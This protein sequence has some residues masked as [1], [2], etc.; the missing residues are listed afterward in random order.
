MTSVH[1][2][3]IVLLMLVANA[4]SIAYDNDAGAEF[5]RYWCDPNKQKFNI[6]PESYSDPGTP[7]DCQQMTCHGMQAACEPNKHFLPDRERLRKEWRRIKS[8]PNFKCK[9]AE[10]PL[11][12]DGTLSRKHSLIDYLCKNGLVSPPNNLGMW[13]GSS[14]PLPR[15]E[16]GIRARIP[17]LRQG[18]I[19]EIGYGN[20]QHSMTVVKILDGIIYVGGS[21]PH[22]ND[23]DLCKYITN[24]RHKVSGLRILH[25]PNTL[26]NCREVQCQFNCD[27]TVKNMGIRHKWICCWHEH[28]GGDWPLTS[29]RSA[30]ACLHWSEASGT[31]W[32][33]LIT[34]RLTFAGCSD[35]VMRLESYSTLNTG[36]GNSCA[37]LACTTDAR[38]WFT[39]GNGDDDDTI[40][41]VEMECPR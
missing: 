7:G 32:D 6:Y 4:L 9:N 20:W 23:L 19:L 30:Y 12:A 8:D 38:D 34:P 18:D 36:V 14:G 41:V 2:T 11:N 25:I 5:I 28:Q 31:T 24:P 39:L 29:K 26:G 33:T 16:G 35:V 3:V 17:E 13:G 21:S 15:N 22:E 40:T 1:R 10:F 27:S 37:L